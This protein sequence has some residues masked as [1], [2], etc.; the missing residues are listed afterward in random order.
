[1]VEGIY[2]F[3]DFFYPLVS[4]IFDKKTYYYAVVGVSN[5]VLSWVLFFLCYQFLF[6]KQFFT[7]SF[8][9]IGSFTF[10]PYTLSAMVSTAFSFVYGFTLLKFIVFTES[11]LKGRI[12]LVRYAM[13]AGVSALSSWFLLKFFIE[14]LHF[15]PSI[16]NVLASC[17]VVVLSYILQ[18]KFTFKN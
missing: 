9:S 10:S 14:W 16:A 15:F 4:K 3:L 12:Q 8:G 7:L 1:M 11:E 18:R 17:I 2:R 6:D 5:L 13:T